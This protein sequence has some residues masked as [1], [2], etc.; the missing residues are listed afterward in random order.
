V[1]WHPFAMFEEKPVG[2][3]ISMSRVIALMF[4]I[5]Y[6]YSL[7]LA[8]RNNGPTTIVGWPYA[9]LGIVVVMAVPLQA[10]FKTLQSWFSTAPGKALIQ[11]LVNKAA[12]GIETKMT[13][14]STVNT[15][16]S[17]PQAKAP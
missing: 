6:C 17:P 7:T 14:T 8:A 3:G 4:A 9:C 1:N 11:T 16:A 15:D 10:L 13:T 5:T 2:S 12:T